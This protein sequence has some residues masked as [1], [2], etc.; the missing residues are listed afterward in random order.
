V[1]VCVCVYVGGGGG[2]IVYFVGILGYFCI[3]PRILAR[4]SMFIFS[5]W[6]VKLFCIVDL[7]DIENVTP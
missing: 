4:G 6:G 3:R 2:G 1:C 7:I 5:P